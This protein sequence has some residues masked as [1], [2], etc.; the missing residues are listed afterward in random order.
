MT[1]VNNQVVKHIIA[2]DG[3]LHLEPE[4]TVDSDPPQPHKYNDFQVANPARFLFIVVAERLHPF[5]NT[6]TLISIP[7]QLST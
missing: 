4:A 3:G 5:W 2:R 1:G 6:K 7:I